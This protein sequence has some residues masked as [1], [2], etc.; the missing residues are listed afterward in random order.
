MFKSTKKAFTII[1]FIIAISIFF[2]MVVASYVPYNHYMNKVKVR[3]TIKEISQVL[4]EARNMAINW[5][6][7]VSNYS[8][9]VYFDKSTHKNE[10]HFISFP[11]NLEES[12]IKLD[13]LQNSANIIKKISLQPNMNIVGI[14]WNK[15]WL[16]LFDAI[17]WKWNYYYF[18]SAWTKQKITNSKIN[19]N[20]SYWSAN[21]W[22]PFSW[23][24]FY[25]TKTNIVDY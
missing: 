13:F 22:S 21:L 17:T 5:T 20:F 18:D 6:S 24:L 11:F 16:F 4:Y 15:N 12:E 3:T 8:V 9:W 14:N 2:I 7:W 10:I 19:I 25:F 1:E 23:E